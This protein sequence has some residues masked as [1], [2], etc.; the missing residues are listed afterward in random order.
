M[1]PV[2]SVESRSSIS[3]RTT[4]RSTSGPEPAA[5]ERTSERCSWARI[6]VGM[7]R[8][9]SAPKPVEMPYAGVGA[10]A[11]SSTTARAAAIAASASAVSSTG[12]PSRATVTTSRSGTGPVPTGTACCMPPSNAPGRALRPAG[13]SD[14]AKD[15]FVHCAIAQ[16]HCWCRIGYGNHIRCSPGHRCMSPSRKAP[17]HASHHSHLDRPG[18]RRHH[19]GCRLA[20]TSNASELAAA[21]KVR[22]DFGMTAT[23]Y[24]TR[25]IGGPLPVDSSQTASMSLS[26]TNKAGINKRNYIANG[27]PRSA[28]RARCHLADL[29][30]EG[31]RHRLVVREPRRRPPQPVQ[32]L[33]GQPG[34][35]RP[36]LPG[37]R[38]PR[39]QGL[40]RPDL[41]QDRVD[42]LHPEGWQA[43]RP[44]HPDH[45]QAAHHPR[46]APALD[47]CRPQGRHRRRR[48]GRDQRPRPAPVPGHA[49]RGQ[50]DRRP[51]QGH[52]RRR[53]QERPLRRLRRR[54][55]GV[56]AR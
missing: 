47:R 21:K 13:A 11:S 19:L 6:S 37:P 4:S 8:V 43:G 12:A 30:R 18:V 23:S 28:H 44:D 48:R 49:Q 35:Q 56:G 10:A 15:K 5:C 7:W 41:Q 45:R 26:C 14:K 54:R 51:D 50:G 46:P 34:H 27:R 39:Q 33:A 38:L 32:Q 40:P 52:H 36:Q 55:P 53:H 42:H 16:I 24:G 25:V 2:A 17:H 29:D 31:R 9:A 22:T 3:A 20:S 1:W